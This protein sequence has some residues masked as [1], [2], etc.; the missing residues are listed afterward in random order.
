MRSAYFLVVIF[1][2]MGCATTP[3]IFQNRY[4][5]EDLPL[6]EAV[7]GIHS[8]TGSAFLRQRGGGIVTCA[9]NDVILSR[10]LSIHRNDYA[11]EY[12]SLNYRVKS[13]S[14]VDPR[15]LE[16]EKK[17]A[18]I[19]EKNTIRT[20]CDVNGKFHFDNISP[21]TYIVKS[22]VYWVVAS[23]GQGGIVGATVVV[24][25]RKKQTT[26][27]VVVDKVISNCTIFNTTCE[28]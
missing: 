23:E 18:E 25:N 13:V 5:P 28:P 26:T 10:K 22:K 8:L 27:S 3:H 17:L 16:F 12:L 4:T 20:T 11:K 9:G 14:D 24:P 2:L 21:G 15:F 1:G 7:S 6:D 19:R